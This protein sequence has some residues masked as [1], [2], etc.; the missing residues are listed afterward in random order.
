MGV[1]NKDTKLAVYKNKRKG[2]EC[3]MTNALQL[4]TKHL[5]FVGVVLA[6]LLPAFAAAQDIDPVVEDTGGFYVTDQPQ[7]GL[8]TGG[9]DQGLIGVIEQII[10]FFAS[11]LAV[12]AILVIVIAGILYITSGGDEGRIQTAKTWL[13]YAIIGLIIALLA[14]VIV[15]TVANA[16]DAGQ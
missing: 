14:W 13:T 5:L 1:K 16:L 10:K 11:I 12:L 8:A 9:D 15:N 6:M 3:D 2:G 7:F 4:Y